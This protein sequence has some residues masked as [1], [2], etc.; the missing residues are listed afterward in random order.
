[1]DGNRER[2][3][4]SNLCKKTWQIWNIVVRTSST[5]YTDTDA[6]C[7]DFGYYWVYPCR[8]GENGEDIIGDCPQYVCAKGVYEE[9]TEEETAN[10]T[11]YFRTH[12]HLAGRTQLQMV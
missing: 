8:T 7:D 10:V 6:L 11:T 4:V 9:V 12:V 2:C 5:S 1:M 3:K